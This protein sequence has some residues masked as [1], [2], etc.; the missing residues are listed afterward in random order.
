MYSS[1]LALAS[2]GVTLVYF[3][4]EIFETAGRVLQMMYL[5]PFSTAT[6]AIAF[7]LLN[8]VS[9]PSGPMD[10]VV[11]AK[12]VWTPVKAGPRDDLSRTSPWT[13]ST[14]LLSSF[15]LSEL[16]SR[17]MARILNF[18]ENSGSFRT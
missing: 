11:M 13:T 3:P 14:F 8:S 12:M 17:V 2:K 15:A 18:W 1:T 7:P 6:S 5:A 9:A 10:G 4:P 16:V